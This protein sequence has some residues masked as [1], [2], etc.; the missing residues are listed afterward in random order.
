MIL[1][2]VDGRE[3]VLSLPQGDAARRVPPW[4]WAAGAASVAAHLVGFWWLHGQGMSAELAR[5][6]VDPA[7]EPIIAQLWRPTPPPP[8][9]EPATRPTVAPRTP[10]APTRPVDTL[11]V[12]PVPEGVKPAEG[13]P[14]LSV[15]PVPDT[16]AAD[17]PIGTGGGTGAATAPPVIENPR[18]ISKPSA[19]ELNRWYPV[20][21][22]EDGVEGKAVIRCSVTVRGA[23]TACSVADETPSGRGFGD[24]AIK[25]SRY[26]RMSPQTVDGR[27]VEGASVTIPIA[28]RLD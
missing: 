27:P 9:P 21:A 20:R 13:E 5:P 11:P 22:L 15:R 10:K 23:L 18:W 1:K 2:T 14:V 4:L 12:P 8:S 28:F 6:S 17:A 16:P 26:F 25:L 7:P 24:A 3:I 19:A